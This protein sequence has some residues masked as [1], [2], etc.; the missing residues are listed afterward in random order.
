MTNDK[1]SLK[2]IYE[3]VD[4][5]EQKLDKRMCQLEGR[6]DVL[7]DFK[8]RILGMAAVVAAFVGSVTAWL[9]KKVTA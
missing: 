2:D 6:V 8:A 4:R 1:V 9:W 3:I 7:E 5:M